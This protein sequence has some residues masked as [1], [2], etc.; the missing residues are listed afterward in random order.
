MRVLVWHFEGGVAPGTDRGPTY[1]TSVGY[2]ATEV[3]LTAKAAAG[4]VPTVIDINDDGVSIF[5]TTVNMAA[6]Q[7][8]ARRR[9]YKA[10]RI[11]PDSVITL[12]VDESGALDNF[13]VELFLEEA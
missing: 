11:E 6:G 12:D 1:H 3:R 9:L 5:K 8:S 10:G 7:L 2:F 13:T 4:L